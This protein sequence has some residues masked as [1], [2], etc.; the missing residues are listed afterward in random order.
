MGSPRFKIEPRDVPPTAVAK[1]LGLTE[2]RFAA[3]ELAPVS[4]GHPA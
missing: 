2:A 4:T 1:F 3:S